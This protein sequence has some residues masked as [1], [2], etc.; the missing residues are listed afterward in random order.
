MDLN[1]C[2]DFK[3]CDKYLKIFRGAQERPNVV[4]SQI[5]GTL[6]VDMWDNLKKTYGISK[7]LQLFRDDV[8][9]FARFYY[10]LWIEYESSKQEMRIMKDPEF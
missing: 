2:L 9:T 7:N 6:N 5:Y 8:Y 4:K 3:S 1:T 10:V